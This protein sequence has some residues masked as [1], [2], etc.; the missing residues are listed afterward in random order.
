MVQTKEPSEL[1]VDNEPVV[2]PAVRRVLQGEGF[3]AI[4]SGEG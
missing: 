3:R 2:H 4:E 1:V